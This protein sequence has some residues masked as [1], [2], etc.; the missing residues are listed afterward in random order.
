MQ[1]ELFASIFSAPDSM[2]F[3]LLSIGHFFVPDLKRADAAIDRSYRTPS[4]RRF[5]GPVHR[6]KAWLHRQEVLD[7]SANS[8]D[9]EEKTVVGILCVGLDEIH[10]TEFL[11]DFSLEVSHVSSNGQSQQCTPF[12]YFRSGIRF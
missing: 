7:R 11:N 8:L 12:S 2:S 1:V 3:L 5:F 9:S 4:K 10:P 6:Q